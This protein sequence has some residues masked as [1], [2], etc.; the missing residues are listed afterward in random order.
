VIFFCSPVIFLPDVVS[1]QAI[2]MLSDF[3]GG[4]GGEYQSLV[5]LQPQPAYDSGAMYAHD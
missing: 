5:I 2:S 4:G 1:G 3:P